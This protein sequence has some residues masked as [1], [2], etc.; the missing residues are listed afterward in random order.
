MSEPIPFTV[1]F[2]KNTIS[3]ALPLDSPVL[4]LKEQLAE[5]TGVEVPKQKLF[6]KGATIRDE[7]TLADL[8]V[9]RNSKLMLIGSTN[10][11][12]HI[13]SQAPN[14]LAEESNSIYRETQYPHR[15][16]VLY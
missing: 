6:L 11:D 5:T 15:R 8:K 4:A 10:S 16:T 13:G 3:V 14:V 2:G 7:M 1:K 9:T 12:I